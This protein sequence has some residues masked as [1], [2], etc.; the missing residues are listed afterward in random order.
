MPALRSR[1]QVHRGINVAAIAGE[2]YRV[3]RN[4]SFAARPGLTAP[5]HFHVRAGVAGEKTHLLRRRRRSV[6]WV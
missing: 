6:M 5:L 3:T 2:P 1:P 4:F